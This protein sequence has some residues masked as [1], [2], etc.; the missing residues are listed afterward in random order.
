MIVAVRLFLITD[1]A[2][3]I[4]RHGESVAISKYP[5]V[6]ARV[7]VQHAAARMLRMVRFAAK[8]AARIFIKGDD[9]CG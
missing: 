8:I 6:K 1:V 3:S 4:S 2:V 7:D 5:N 9:Q